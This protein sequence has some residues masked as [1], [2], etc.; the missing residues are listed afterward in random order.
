MVADGA[1][2]SVS[3]LRR[4]YD[5]VWGPGFAAVY[6]I[7]LAP[8]EL[9]GTAQIRR[10]VLAPAAG[11]VVEIGAG[12]GLNVAHYPGAVTE[13]VL[14]EPEAAM[15][16]RLRR[17]AA[18]A[19]GNGRPAPDVIEAPGQSL[20]FDDASFD[21][22]AF[23]MVLCTAPDPDAVL[24]EIARVLKPGGR[25]FFFEHVR[26]PNRLLARAQDAC[27]GAW[28]VWARGCRCNQDALAI[29]ERS[30]LELEQARE[31]ILPWNFPLVRPMVQGSAR[32]AA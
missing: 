8:T 1:N 5:A 6:D 16:K 17:R 19:G 23:T 21:A 15:A 2:G 31:G 28:R 30:P 3:L 13:L 29:L 20:P 18:A 9:G 26:S 7:V 22:A 10:D 11:R 12:T 14:T 27:A 4:A 24:A 32:R 25:V